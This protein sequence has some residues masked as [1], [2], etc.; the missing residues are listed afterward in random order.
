MNL[1]TAIYKK[2]FSDLLSKFSESIDANE[3]AVFT[4]RSE[5]NTFVRFNH[6]KVRQNTSLDQHIIMCKFQKNKRVVEFGFQLVIDLTTDLNKFLC[7]LNDSRI[8]MSKMDASSDYTPINSVLKS[9]SIKKINRPPDEQIIPWICDQFKNVDM[10]GFWCSGPVVEISANHL[11]QYH[12]FES[13]FFFFDYSIYSGPRAVKSLYSSELWSE[14]NFKNNINQSIQKLALLKKDLKTLNKGSYR[15]YLE[16]AAVDEILSTLNWGGFSQAQYKQGLSPLKKL[17]D[18]DCA[19]SGKISLTENL[20]LGL[21]PNFNSIGEVVSEPLSIIKNGQINNLMT[22]TATALEYGIESNYAESSEFIKSLDLAPGTLS[23]KDVLE[24]LDTG[25]YLSNLHYI[26]WS[27]RSN[28]RLTGMTRFACYWVENGEIQGPIQ[29]MRF[30][31]SIYNLLGKNLID[32]TIERELMV[33]TGTY[34]TRTLG[35]TLA[36]GLLVDDMNFT[37]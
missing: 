34:F 5:Q 23:I 32:L 29:D 19:L 21:A 33:K 18:K 22:S 8:Q 27:D 7:F 20:T 17:I 37:L 4:L 13:D 31:D 2:Y 9:E 25:I 35:A 1:Q 10:V 11:G 15:C 36:P 6:S 14:V 16:P 3:E 30:D 28:A 24:Q 12:Y 26:N